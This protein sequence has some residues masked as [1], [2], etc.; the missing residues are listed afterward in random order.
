MRILPIRNSFHASR[1]LPESTVLL[2]VP[3]TVSGALQEGDADGLFLLGV[4]CAWGITSRAM[5]SSFLVFLHTVNSAQEVK[6]LALHA[7]VVLS[8]SLP[9]DTAKVYISHLKFYIILTSAHEHPEK[10]IV[11]L[12]FTVKG[13]SGGSQVTLPLLLMILW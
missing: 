11:P 1:R 12:T 2:S 9:P 10:A 3:I 5:Q 4:P 6:H 13:E 7:L 8:C